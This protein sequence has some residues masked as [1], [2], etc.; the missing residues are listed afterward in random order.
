MAR[1]ADF[2]HAVKQIGPWGFVKRVWQETSDDNVFTNAAAMAYAWAFAVFPFLIFLLTLLPY[3]PA[4]ARSA[5]HHFIEQFMYRSG[6]TYS[7]VS[8][9]L[10][11]LD[12]V[13]SQTHS[14]FLSFGIILTLYAASGG[15]NTTMSALDEAFEV[16]NPRSFIWKRLWAMV[17]TLFA[18]LGVVII[19]IALP[20]SGLALHF[21]LTHLHDLPLPGWLEKFINTPVL[22]LIT[23][24]RYVIGLFAMQLMIGFL[25]RFG[26]SRPHR[27]RFLSPGAIFATV[28]W[29]ATG[30]GMRFYFTHFAETSYAKTYGIVAG[31]IIMLLVFYLDGIIV[32]IGAEIDSEVERCQHNPDGTVDCISERPID[33]VA[34]TKQVPNPT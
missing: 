6:M 30:A 24:L 9:V 16:E 33:P 2:I 31:M 21:L 26:P 10:D 4:N 12:K 34:A 14:G 11:P 32:L 20:V 23:L 22:V 1:V 19:L 29:I 3:L 25:Y 7:V 28:G 5:T 18:C 15:M 8:L 13:M 17:L 27:L